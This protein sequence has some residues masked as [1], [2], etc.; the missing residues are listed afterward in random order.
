MKHQKEESSASHIEILQEAINAHPGKTAAEL[1]DLT[2]LDYH[3]VWR[4]L[5]EMRTSRLVK[6]GPPQKCTVK[7]NHSAGWWPAG[8]NELSVDVKNVRI[9]GGTQPRTEINTEVVSDYAEHMRGGADFPPVVVFF[10]GV[11]WWLADGFHRVHAARQAGIPTIKAEV[12]QGTKRDAILYSVGAN[13]D[14]GQRRTPADKRKAVETLLTNPEVAN[15]PQTG[16]PWSDTS[17]AKRCSVSVPFVGKVRR[18]LTINV[19][20]EQLTTRTFTDKHGNT[21]TMNTANIGK[22]PKAERVEKISQMASEGYRAAQI[23]TEMNVAIH[24]VRKIARE[25]NINLADTQIGKVT[26]IDAARV[27]EQTVTGLEGYASGLAV[28]GLELADI[29]QQQAE[30][31]ERAMTEAMKPINRLK[32]RLKEIAYD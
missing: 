5:P 13:A 17:C 28:I 27:I 8:N 11:D 15:D 12:H 3:A 32:K 21:T 18:G 19:N 2:G 14:H 7:G 31:W 22:R 30:E 4:R 25:E 16:Q 23:A 6:K 10:D 24:Y 20:S 29:P 1:A 9:D 26:R